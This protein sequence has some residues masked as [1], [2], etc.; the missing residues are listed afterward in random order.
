MRVLAL[1]RPLGLVPAPD[2]APQQPVQRAGHQRELQF[3]VDLQRHGRGQR[4]HEKEIDGLGDG[5]LDHHPAGV[6]VR[7]VGGPVLELVGERQGGLLVAEVGDGDLADPAGVLA[8]LDQAVERAGM[9]ELAA[10][11]AQR[12]LL[13]A[14]GGEQLADHLRGA[15]PQGEE[16]DAEL[17]QLG[18]RGV[19]GEAG[20]EHQLAGQGAGALAV[21]VDKVQDGVAPVLLAQGGVSAAE[22]VLL[23]VADEEGKHGA[24]AAAALGDG[25][26][27]EECLAAVAGDGVEVEGL[28]GIELAGGPWGQAAGGDAAGAP[29]EGGALRAKIRR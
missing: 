5:V 7:Q 8:Q 26:L 22:G 15:L 1:A 28:G 24:P 14:V 23:G 9:A 6:A 20:V 18:E 13:P 4:V 17:L 3:G 11:V 2:A 27:F 29:G 12:E 21:G 10:D 16:A 25:M 19:G